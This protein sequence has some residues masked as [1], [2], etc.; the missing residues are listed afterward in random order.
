MALAAG[1]ALVACSGSDEPSTYERA[2]DRGI[3]IKRSTFDE[4]SKKICKDS[5]E[6]RIDKDRDAYAEAIA[7]V[8]S[9][10]KNDATWLVRVVELDCD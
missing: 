7:S 8:T 1:C 9:A 6:G 4:L 10:D 3:D 2:Q 5:E